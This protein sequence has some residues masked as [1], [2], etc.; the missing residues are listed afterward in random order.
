MPTESAPT[1]SNSSTSRPTSSTSWRSREQNAAPARGGWAGPHRGGQ[2]PVDNAASTR[3]RG[4][5]SR[6]RGGPTRQPQ[7]PPRTGNSATVTSQ[8]VPARSNTASKN[9]ETSSSS[10]N[11]GRNPTPKDTSAL[12]TSL[13]SSTRTASVDSDD[14]S[15]SEGRS[16]SPGPASSN[17]PPPPPPIAFWHPSTFLC[18]FDDCS[19]QAPVTDALVALEHLKDEHGIQ[20]AEPTGALP[21]LEKYITY[22]AK[23]AAEKGP[24]NV[25]GVKTEESTANGKPVYLLAKDLVDED[26][27][28]RE[29]LQR[30]K[31]NEMLKVQDRERHEDSLQPRKCL[32]CKLVCDSRYVIVIDGMLPDLVEVNEFL[33]TLQVKLA[34]LQCLYCEKIFKTS[35]VLRKHMRKKKHFKINPRNYGYDRFYIINYVEFEPGKNW[36]TYQ[37]DKYDSDEDRKDD[38]WDDWNEDT[39]SEL[40]MCLFD[41]EVF[42]SPADAHNH[43]KSAHGFDLNDIRHRLELDFYGSIRLINFIRRQTSLSTCYACG[44]KFENVPE[45]T[46][47]ME[48][49]KH[50]VDVKKEAEFWSDPQN[51]FPCYENDPLLMFD[52]ALADEDDESANQAA[53]K[54]AQEEFRRVALQ[55]HLRRLQEDEEAKE[56]DVGGPSGEAAP[57]QQEEEHVRPSEEEEERERG[58]GREEV[59]AWVGKSSYGIVK[60]E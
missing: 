57:V 29:K 1:E 39:E 48:K 45:M 53:I 54:E 27:G 7:G 51:L 11:R 58:G 3:G 46:E 47:H 5:A 30:E 8:P 20:I 38:A 56:G 49:E 17:A 41:E 13:A 44:K 33:D 6:G 40:T 32:F 26:R 15:D 42:P 2:R 37:N 43:M 18:P 23:R 55:D 31:L 22:W 14:S 24:G 35:A 52:T 59:V 25:G 50:F 60:G 28:Y 36:E 10:Y 4:G 19:L 16:P 12:S 9:N 34:G 21:F